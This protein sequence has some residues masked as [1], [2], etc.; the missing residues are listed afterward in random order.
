MRPRGDHCA[1]ALCTC[2]FM[3]VAN[4]DRPTLE[5]LVASRVRALRLAFHY[6]QA[7]LA[8]LMTQ[9]GHRM[10]QTTVAALESASRP[11]R[12]DEVE[13][14][15]AI[16]NTSPRTLIEPP[17]DPRRLS[18]EQLEG[19]IDRASLQVARAQ[20]QLASLLDAQAN[21]HST[22]TATT[23]DVQRARAHLESRQLEL[24]EM[25]TALAAMQ[26]DLKKLE[27]QEVPGGE[28]REAP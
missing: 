12:V 18:L 22:L 21:A 5:R 28:H 3:A 2:I 24:A 17:L 15:A 8:E 11:I 26:A 13:A 25:T 20:G 7:E 23:A 19:R 1:Q 10:H 16:F 4:S 14:L 9:H 6:T 27:E